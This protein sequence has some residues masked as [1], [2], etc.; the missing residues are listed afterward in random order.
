MIAGLAAIAK[1]EIEADP[2]QFEKVN[3]NSKYLWY[4]SDK[5]IVKSEIDKNTKDNL[6][7]ILME[8]GR[9]LKSCILHECT[10]NRYMKV[11]VIPSDGERDGRALEVISKDIVLEKID[12]NEFPMTERHKLTGKY[13]ASDR[14]TIQTILFSFISDFSLKNFSI[15]VKSDDL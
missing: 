3:E 6:E 10:E 9:N 8:E 12:L 4:Y 15:K 1:I 2:S 11:I 5:E 7:W 14:F 13:L